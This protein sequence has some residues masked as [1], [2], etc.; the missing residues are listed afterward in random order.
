[1]AK[2]NINNDIINNSWYN[3]I[4][5]VVSS[6]SYWV[7]RGGYVSTGVLSGMFQFGRHSGNGDYRLGFRIVLSN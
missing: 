6:S 7:A 5:G 2:K 3:D 4:E 1:L